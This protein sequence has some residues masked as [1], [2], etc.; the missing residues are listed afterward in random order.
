MKRE[1]T[2]CYADG[3]VLAMSDCVERIQVVGSIRRG[4]D[5]VG[6]IELLII[7]KWETIEPD[8]VLFTESVAVNRL[9]D[10]AIRPDCPVRWIKP[11]TNEIVDWHVKPDGKY[12]RGYLAKCDLKLDIFLVY[13]ESW[14]MQ[15][16]IR[17]GPAEFSTALMVHVNECG[18]TCHDGQLWA[19]ETPLRCHTEREVFELLNLVPLAPHNRH[20]AHSLR[21]LRQATR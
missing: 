10:W 7:P 11:A 15:Q 20:G 17:T 4:K 16:L 1:I 5:D 8:G 18:F 13:S 19:N 3:L 9:H 12:W 14:G 6:D 2:R 21:R